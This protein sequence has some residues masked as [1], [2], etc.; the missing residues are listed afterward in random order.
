M[1]TVKEVKWYCVVAYLFIG[2]GLMAAEAMAGVEGDWEGTLDTGSGT[3]PLVI[4]LSNK[5]DQWQGTLD[6]PAQ[7]GFDMPMSKV[8]FQENHLMFELDQLGIHYEGTYDATKDNIQ[9]KFIQGTS[10][11]L[12]FNRVIKEEHEAQMKQEALLGDWSG[13]IQTPMGPLSFVIH[14]ELKDGK[15]VASA[16]SPDQ[17]AKGIPIES[18]IIKDGEV[19]F[20]IESIGASYTA[21]FL[22]G[23]DVLDG[24]FKQGP[25]VLPLIMDKKPLETKQANRPQTPKAPFAYDVEEVVVHNAKADIDLAGSLTL[26]KDRKIRAAAIMIT[27]SGGQDRDETLFGHKP[28]LVIA[29][30]LT[31]QGYAV[32]RMD[33]RGMG[34]SSGS[35]ET[36]TSADFVTDIEAAMNFLQKRS[37]IPKNKIGLIGHSEG[38]MIAPM[39]AAQRDDV[40]FVIMLAGPGIKIVDL[41]AQ[42]RELV[43]STMGLPSDSVQKITRLDRIAFDKINQLPLGAGPDES[44]LKI[45]KSIFAAAGAPDGEAQVNQAQELMKVWTSPWFRYFLQFDPAPYLA[46]TKTPILAINGELDIQVTAKENL[47][48]I[49]KTLEKA[50]HPDFETK[51]YP[52]LNHLFQT[53]KTGAITEYAQIEQ[54]MATIVLDDMAKWLNKRFKAN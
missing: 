36:S 24:Q 1:N 9:G 10:F 44:L 46:K 45:G 53:A 38:G 20:K 7:G 6:S 28:F 26:P 2:L 8:A 51:A 42:Q 25:A 18:V 27:G 49:K 54:T 29:D 48:G 34:G 11:T 5:Q 22:L 37:D 19:T 41:Y 32:L 3:L 40:A 16:D 30:H 13:V 50:S 43:F 15:L 14:V 52:Q 33:D 31:K 35:M 21:R 23:K 4:H 47:A 12:N 17:G 39:V